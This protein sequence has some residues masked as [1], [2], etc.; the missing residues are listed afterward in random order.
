MSVLLIGR[1]EAAADADLVIVESHSMRDGD[2]KR[3]GALL[4]GHAAAAALWWCEWLTDS[5]REAVRAVYET[6][7]RDEGVR[8]IDEV[9]GADPAN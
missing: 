7:V 6:Y 3:R 5:H 9:E 8:L 4:A 1:W 2:Q